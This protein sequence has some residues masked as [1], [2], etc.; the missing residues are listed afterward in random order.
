[1]PGQGVNP[2]RASQSDRALGESPL[3]FAPRRTDTKMPVRDELEVEPDHIRKLFL[4]IALKQLVRRD[5]TPYTPRRCTAWISKS[6]PLHRCGICP[7]VSLLMRRGKINLPRQ[8]PRRPVS[9]VRSCV[10]IWRPSWA[11]SVFV[12]SSRARSG[13]RGSSLAARGACQ[14]GWLFGRVGR[15]WSAS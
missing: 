13:Q 9:S 6:E 2:K 10:R 1:M 12:R 15:T 7:S 8:K 5:A 14:S 3:H 11:T 4:A